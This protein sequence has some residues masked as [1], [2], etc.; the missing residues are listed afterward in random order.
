MTCGKTMEI[1][2]CKEFEGVNHLPDDLE[3]LRLM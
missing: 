3:K 1:D 2:A